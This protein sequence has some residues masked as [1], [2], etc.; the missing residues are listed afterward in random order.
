MWYEYTHSLMF[1]LG[2]AGMPPPLQTKFGRL[3][4]DGRGPR[5]WACD[6]NS[7]VIY[8]LIGIS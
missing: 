4:K 7:E 3:R 6:A 2:K 8:F 5:N 1:C